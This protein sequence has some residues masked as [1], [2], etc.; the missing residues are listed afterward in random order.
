[1]DKDQIINKTKEYVKG[2]LYG[3]GTGHDWWHILR[4]YNISMYIGKKENADMFV[5]ELTALLH[6]IADWKF[7]E[8]SSEVGLKLSRD[9]LT[10]LGVDDTI[11]NKIT[12]IIGTM[13]FKGGTTNSKQETIEGKVVQDADRLDAIGAIGIARAFAYG[14]YKERELYNP[15]IKPQKHTDFEQYK[16]NIGTTINHFYEK[17]LLLKDLMNTESGRSIARERHK[18]MEEYLK[19]F[20]CE[21]ECTDVD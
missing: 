19:H 16:K 17:L 13:S 10:S 9:W 2:K 5:V 1:M 3:E 6:D 8:G 14:G 20:F 7:N 15:N 21:W 4:V 18:F 11:I 12:N